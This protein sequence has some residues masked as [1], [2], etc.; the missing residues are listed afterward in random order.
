[1][2]AEVMSGVV[3][4]RTESDGPLLVE[5]LAN[6]GGRRRQEQRDGALS[7]VSVSARREGAGGSVFVILRPAGP[8]RRLNAIRLQGRRRASSGSSVT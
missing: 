1:M 5:K 4:R 7:G 8:G 6:L 2:R 3:E